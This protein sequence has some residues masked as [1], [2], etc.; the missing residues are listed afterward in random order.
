LHCKP[1]QRIS[2]KF[3]VPQIENEASP[4]LRI[5]SIHKRDTIAGV[6][7]F[8]IGLLA[9]LQALGFD[10]AS[11]MFPLSI[12]GLLAASGLGIA[13]GS[14]RRPAHPEDPAQPMAGV[15]LAALI[16]AAW[17]LALAHGG[18]FLIPTFIMQVLL[19]RVT[20]IRRPAYLVGIALLVA[21]FAYLLFVVLLEI[22]L[23]PSRLPAVLPGF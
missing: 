3:S 16:I 22:P 2:V 1:P 20:G 15:I 6:L 8:L 23:P 17:A 14:L 21:T 13:I 7:L 10:A 12:A 18:G 4:G 11:R 9:S 19:L 5:R